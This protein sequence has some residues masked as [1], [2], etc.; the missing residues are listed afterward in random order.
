MH[1]HAP[2]DRHGY[3]RR[4]C[5]P[6]LE[7][8]E[9]RELLASHPIGPAVP[10]R[11]QPAADVQQFV[12][13][14]YPPGTP[15]PTAA[16][17]A[18]ESFVAKAIGR[19][20]VGAGRFNTQSITIH[21]YGKSATSNMSLKMRFQFVIFEPTDPA[22]PVT[23][24]MNFLGQNYLN[25]GSQMILDLKGPTGTEVNGLPTHLYWARDN[26]SGGP[27]GGPGSALPAYGNFP[28]NYFT[29]NG[30]LVSPL[31]QGLPP[32]SVDNWNMGV[33]DA[34]FKYVPDKHPLPGT[35]GSGTVILVFRGLINASGAQSTA[36][37]NYN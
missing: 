11:H 2:D 22:L 25:N 16:E 1:A 32:T 35:L 4:K 21:G 20:T 15:Q 7:R 34:A 9:Y 6:E 14:L 3:R 26:A 18:R 24:T 29:S 8:L 31:Q 36:D 30:T 12:P 37:K 13:I 28:S 27:F 17:V 19:Y 5:R 10:G 23:G 33:G